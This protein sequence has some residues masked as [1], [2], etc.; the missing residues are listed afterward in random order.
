MYKHPNNCT[1]FLSLQIMDKLQSVQ[2][3]LC[4]ALSDDPD[5]IID[6]CGDKLTRNEDRKIQKQSSP[7]EKMK[8]L[9]N[10]IVEKGGETCQWF[11]DILREHQSHYPQ[12]PQ[13]IGGTFPV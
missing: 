6:E 11:W 13:L 5:Y 12:L 4:R 3:Q 7:Y 1:L 2:D 9:L 10:M 8:V